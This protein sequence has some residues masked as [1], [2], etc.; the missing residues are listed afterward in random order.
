MLRP[1]GTLPRHDPLAARQAKDAELLAGVLAARTLVPVEIPRTHVRGR[2][3]LL[4]RIEGE[5]VRHECRRALADAGL[6]DA[7]RSPAPEAWRE[8]H[9][10]LVVRV[11]AVAVRRTDVDAP[12]APFEEWAICDDIQIRVLWLR[13]QDLETSL[14]PLASAELSA[15]QLAEILDAAKKKD[16]ALLTSYGSYAL[17]T[18]A[19]TSASQPVS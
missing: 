5:Q 2:M 15:A 4:S 16:V 7:A 8:W 6:I 19:I 10:A 17:A 11:L 13:Y 14:D 9:E 3:R 18:F 12:L 1:D